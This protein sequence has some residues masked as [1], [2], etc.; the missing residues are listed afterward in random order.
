RELFRIVRLFYP[1]VRSGGWE[2]LKK[3]ID[4]GPQVLDNFSLFLAEIVPFLQLI[5]NARNCVE[6]P[7]EEQ[8]LVVSDFCV[9]S[10]NVLRSPSIQIVHPRTPLDVASV[11]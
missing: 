11:N 6:H 1:D 4:E 8:K 10:Q 7:R 2:A 9:D 3:R 5:R